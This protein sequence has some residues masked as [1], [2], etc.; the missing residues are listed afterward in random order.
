MKICFFIGYYP[1]I[2]GGA[3]YQSRLICDALKNENE[4]FYISY[5]HEF[6]DVQV[7][8][9]VKVYKLSLS[10]LT[11]N[12]YTFYYFFIKKV[13]DILNVEKPDIVYQRV[14]NSFSQYIASFA[15][16][17]NIR[18]I[19][20]IADE[21]S[22]IFND[23]KPS[24]IVRK[25]FFKRL[26]KYNPIFICQTQ[27]QAELLMKYNI[28]ANKIIPNI[29]PLIGSD[30]KVVRKSNKI[31]WVANAR[32]FKRL[33][34]FLDIANRFKGTDLEFH[35]IGRLQYADNN[36]LLYKI[37]NSNVIYHGFK[38]NHYVNDLLE[39]ALISVNTSLPNSEGLPNTFIQSWMLGT[40][41]IS[42]D[43]NPNYYFKNSFL[44][45]YCNGDINILY[46]G[47]RYYLDMNENTYYDFS[48]KCREFAISEFSLENNI[49]KLK[50]LI[51][52]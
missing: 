8:D 6:D 29:T 44:G 50:D 35:V 14:L 36:A 5:G 41:V 17:N 23:F 34:I 26:I 11:K 19:L 32:P 28:V 1:Q 22:L 3:E 37:I 21:K 12:R 39:S 9:N 7:I 16:K 33:E 13:F 20:H 43:S 40:P 52:I 24:T 48:Q 10:P 42:L 25:L 49:N 27:N 46:N 51:N 45:N 18:F 2:V 30:K 31:L 15:Y 4:I 47:I 38:D